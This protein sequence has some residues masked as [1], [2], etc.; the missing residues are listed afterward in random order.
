M[1]SRGTYVITTKHGIILSP[2]EESRL[3]N[4]SSQEESCIQNGSPQQDAALSAKDLSP[5]SKSRSSGDCDY[6]S[7]KG[8]VK[9]SNPAFKDGRCADY[10]KCIV[11]GCD[12]LGYRGGF[13]KNMCKKHGNAKR[14]KEQQDQK[15]A[16]KKA[17]GEKITTAVG[18]M[19]S[20][21]CRYLRAAKEHFNADVS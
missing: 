1:I 4:G 16:E 5:V 19:P 6:V 10:K 3:K 8:K 11:E 15:Q 14:N 12:K 7:R 17:E 2:Q 18:N 20:P 21:I 9:C 13:G